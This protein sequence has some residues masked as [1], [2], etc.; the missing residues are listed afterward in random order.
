[1][2]FVPKKSREFFSLGGGIIEYDKTQVL[3][4]TIFGINEEYFK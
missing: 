4:V 2:N 3:V 1:M